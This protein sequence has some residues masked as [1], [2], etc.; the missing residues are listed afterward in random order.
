[1]AMASLTTTTTRGARVHVHMSADASSP[2][3]S[4]GDGKLAP[5]AQ[6]SA[7]A[8][9]PLSAPPLH[10]RPFP[11]NYIPDS[12]AAGLGF[13]FIIPVAPFMGVLIGFSEL[14]WAA[15]LYVHKH[16]RLSFINNLV[17]QVAK[18]VGKLILNDPRNYSFL[19]YIFF[20]TVWAPLL[21][22]WAVYQK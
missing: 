4:I 19:P 17:A 10:W 5:C 14:V 11:W 21:F 13:M 2:G 16:A 9:P 3:G 7:S 22:T 18:R 1:M 6:T 20:L 8:S 15:C 12:V